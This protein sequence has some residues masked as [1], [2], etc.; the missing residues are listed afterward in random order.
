MKILA[1]GGAG[2]VPHLPMVRNSVNENICLI[3]Y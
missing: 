1:T 3:K 2:L